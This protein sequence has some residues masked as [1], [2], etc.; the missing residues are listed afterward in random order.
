MQKEIQKSMS[1]REVVTRH[2][3]IFVSDGRV[4]ERKKIRRSRIKSGMTPL[5]NNSGFTLIELLVAVLII[6]ILAAVALPQYQKAVWKSRNTQLKTLVRNIAQARDAY[7]LANGSYPTSFEELSI[8]L[9]FTL[10]NSAAPHI[11]AA[12][13][14]SVMKAEK[15]WIAIAESGNIIGIWVTEPYVGGGFRV[16][17][18]S[19]ILECAERKSYTADQNKFCKQLEK[20]TLKETSNT[21]K[22]YT[23]P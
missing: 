2:L 8:D 20:A 21:Y 12:G 18:D 11:N 1:C 15:F 17:V 10:A 9:P 3:R 6:G 22:Y 13:P 5:F 7:Y 4:N 16:A 14:G 19:N 23:L